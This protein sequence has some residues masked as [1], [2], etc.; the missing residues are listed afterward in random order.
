VALQ[1]RYLFV[2]ENLI[3]FLLSLDVKACKDCPGLT[4][5]MDASEVSTLVA[6]PVALNGA[7]FPLYHYLLPD[8]NVLLRN[9][10]KNL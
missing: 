3:N 1:W 2:E 7:K 9:V 10:S 6:A 4:E 5:D 8:A